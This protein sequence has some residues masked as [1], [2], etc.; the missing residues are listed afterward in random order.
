MKKVGREP[1]RPD[2]VSPLPP[3]HAHTPGGGAHRA[4]ATHGSPFPA[5]NA[6]AVEQ[7]AQAA[8]EPGRP[9]GW[10][11]GGAGRS[12]RQPPP[13]RGH[14]GTAV[15]TV[16]SLQSSRR[17]GHLPPGTPPTSPGLRP[18]RAS[19]IPSSSSNMSSAPA[20]GTGRSRKSGKAQ[21]F[22]AVVTRSRSLEL[23]AGRTPQ[24]GLDGTSRP[25]PPGRGCRCDPCGAG[26]TEAWWGSQSPQGQTAS[27]VTA[28]IQSLGT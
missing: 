3:T 11:A 14:A 27:P 2:C 24:S 18:F 17:S 7:S 9:S 21:F 8:T 19:S 12:A 28:G 4:G 5:P 20:S 15:A 23:L 10:D 25:P 6:Q 1:G 13:R 22:Y 16:L 26:G